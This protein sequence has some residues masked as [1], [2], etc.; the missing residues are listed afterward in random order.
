M[1]RGGIAGPHK[2]TGANDAANAQEQQIPGTKRP[3]QFAMFGF[4][5]NLLDTFPCHDAGHEPKLLCTRHFYSLSE[6]LRANLAGNLIGA[7]K[8]Q[9]GSIIPIWRPPKI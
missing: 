1:Q 3:F 8:F 2:D 7:T 4:A 5:L 9:R 6:P